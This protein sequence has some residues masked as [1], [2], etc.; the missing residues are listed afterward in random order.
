M[1]TRIDA[2]GRLVI[3]KPLRDQYRFEP[4]VEIEI[5]T[6]PDGITLLPIMRKRRIIRRG[7]IAAV[8]TGAGTAP[9]QI[10]SVDR[11]RTGHSEA[12]ADVIATDNAD[13]FRRRAPSVRIADPT[14]L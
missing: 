11:V 7:R 4:G 1:K 2:S 6:I 5:V 13:D 12:G 10:F 8:D 3:P 14:E 9:V